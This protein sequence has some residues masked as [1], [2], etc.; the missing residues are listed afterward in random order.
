MI[1]CT[2][3]P[4]FLIPSTKTISSVI[5]SYRNW[6]R[7]YFQHKTELVSTNI[8]QSIEGYVFSRSVPDSVP[9]NIDIH[10]FDDATRRRRNGQQSDQT[11]KHWIS[12]CRKAEK[13]SG[14]LRW[15]GGVH[16]IGDKWVKVERIS[17]ETSSVLKVCDARSIKSEKIPSTTQDR[18]GWQNK[19]TSWRF[20]RN[21]FR[22]L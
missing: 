16:Y 15:T 21:V 14:T 13:R 1:P 8:S 19:P 18:E 17:L 3:E 5:G 6:A 7:K 22:L 12:K 9:S 20:L 4:G 10:I 11:Y 2:S